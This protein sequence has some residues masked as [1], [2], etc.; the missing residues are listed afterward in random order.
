MENSEIW[1][2]AAV[3]VKETAANWNQPV[4]FAL[5]VLPSTLR[6][7]LSWL[8]TLLPTVCEKRGA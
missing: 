3:T 1:P 7:K 5:G 4:I 2:D 8:V 6:V